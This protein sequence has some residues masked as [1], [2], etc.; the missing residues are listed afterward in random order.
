MKFPFPH[1]WTDKCADLL[2]AFNDNGVEYLLI[3]S[4]AKAFHC[5][6]LSPAPG[7]ALTQLLEGQGFPAVLVLVAA[8]T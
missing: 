5:P 1:F 7:L 6:E 8:G 3:G 2:R 4:M